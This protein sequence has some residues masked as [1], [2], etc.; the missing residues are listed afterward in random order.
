MRRAFVKL[1][2]KYRAAL[3]V[4][5]AVADWPYVEDVTAGFIYLRLHGPET[6]YGGQ[7]S[8]KALDRWAQ[9]IAAWADGSEP[10]MR[11]AFR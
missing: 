11:G 9:R 5:D 7:Y 8:D 4:S 1:L 3:V 6:L 10:P 2:R